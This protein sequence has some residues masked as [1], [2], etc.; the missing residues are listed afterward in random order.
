MMVNRLVL[1]ALLGLAAVALAEHRP[2]KLAPIAKKILEAYPIPAVPEGYES[3]NP[4]TIGYKFRTRVDHFNPQNRDTFEFEYFSNDQFYQP[5]GPIFIFVGG[6]WPLSQYYIEAGHFFSIANYENA[7]LF[8]NE[9]RYYG[10][11][12]PVPDLSLENLQYLTVEQAMVDLAELIYHLKRNVVRDNNA[13]VILLGTGYAGAI[14]TWMRQRY[15]HLVEGAWVSSGQIEARLNFQ[16]Y[17]VEIGELIRNYG[18]SECYSQIW[19]AF[20]T[21]ENLIDAGLSNTV[22]DL[23]NTCKPLD[24]DT[25]LDVETF[26]YN[27]KVAL[28]TAVLLEQNIEK[29]D[30][31]CQDLNNST[32]PT[33]LHTIAEWIEDFYYYLDCM[34]FD[35][36]TTVEAHQ[37]EQINY[38]ENSILGLRQRVYQFCT[39]FGW[40]LTSTADD[41]PFGLRV[42][43]Y[44]FQNFC[45][46]V[47]GDW[48]N[49]EVVADGVSLTNMHFG[50]KNPRISN[51]LFTNGGLDPVRDIG[52]TSYYQPASG[53]IVIPGYFNSEDLAAI[54]G[55]NSPEMLEAKYRIH[56][57]I[58]LWVWMRATPYNA[59]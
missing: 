34:P 4:H 53:A 44:F 25:N 31:L 10:N 2:I 27:V 45:K 5:G 42:T 54:S 17:A 52:I 21:A 26:F 57:Y 12:F 13:R 32:E 39:E 28:Q 11:S 56:R 24:A 49:E 6:N 1:V 35:F 33:D 3:T 23:F 47:F 8:A 46:S 20:R 58:E 38:P 43:L 29:T 51:V 36:D 55:Y 22:T 41:Q 16:E 48:L 59:Q 7:W 30:A 50:G 15:P 40:F 14:A 18:N 19:R 37:F 9:H